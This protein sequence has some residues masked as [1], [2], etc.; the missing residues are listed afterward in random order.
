MV[1]VKKYSGI[2]ISKIVKLNGV[3]KIQ[4]YYI[5]ILGVPIF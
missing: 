2:M 3:K 4:D 5:T 1:V